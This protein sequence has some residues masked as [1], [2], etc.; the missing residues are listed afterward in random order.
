MSKFLL[1]QPQPVPE[2][3]RFSDVPVIAVTPSVF[4]EFKRKAIAEGFDDFLG[5][6]FRVG[7]LMEL[8]QKHL[9]AEFV[10][11]AASGTEGETEAAPEPAGD[12]EL[13]DE[14]RE[15]LLAALQIRNLTAINALAEELAGDPATSAHG[16]EIGR[17]AK[18]FDF[19]GLK[20][21]AET[22]QP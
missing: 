21:I 4:P 7:E 9:K 17:L 19:A 18:S 22:D 20:K 10:D 5:K 12:S 15:K 6:P 13:P 11:R 8:L 3:Q 14:V 16:A 1:G 2:A